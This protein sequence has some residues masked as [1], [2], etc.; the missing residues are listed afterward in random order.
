MNPA[1]PVLILN[2]WTSDSSFLA[3]TC[4]STWDENRLAFVQINQRHS[5][6][7]FLCPRNRDEYRNLVQLRSEFFI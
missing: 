2:V 5:E 1:D 3:L 4:F 6:A 7:T